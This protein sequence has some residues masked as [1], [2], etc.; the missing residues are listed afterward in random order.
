MGHNDLIKKALLVELYKNAPEEIKQIMRTNEEIFKDKSDADKKVENS[1]DS[2][3]ADSFYDKDGFT[4][5]R[6]FEVPELSGA[7][8]ENLHRIVMVDKLKNVEN[9]VSS[10]H[11]WVKFW[12]IL[13]LLGAAVYIFVLLVINS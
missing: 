9:T 8:F 12:S 10:T 4:K 7:D 3:H 5:W 13:S 6:V 1:S 11:F 2:M